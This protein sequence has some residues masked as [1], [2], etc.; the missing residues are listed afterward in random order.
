MNQMKRI[1]NIQSCR[2]WTRN[3]ELQWVFALIKKFHIKH[4]HLHLLKS[5]RVDC[6]STN[7]KAGTWY[8]TMQSLRV[9]Q[10]W[11]TR[12]G[13]STRRDPPDAAG[14]SL[15]KQLKQKTR[16]SAEQITSHTQVLNWTRSDVVNRMFLLWFTM[17]IFRGFSIL[18]SQVI[19]IVAVMSVY[20]RPCGKV[21]VSKSKKN[22]PPLCTRV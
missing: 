9:G 15:K 1:C 22:W 18:N 4:N 7:Q 10:T 20:S 8:S 6:E 16:I 12:E 2:L 13:A 11:A 17:T 19:E 21:K 3:L 5:N 14:C